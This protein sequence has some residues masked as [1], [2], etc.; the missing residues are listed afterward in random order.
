P[1]A[2]EWMQIT[3]EIALVLATS[4]VMLTFAG[5]EHVLQILVDLLFLFFLV[6]RDKP[7]AAAL[8]CC[9]LLVGATRYEG[10]FLV[11]VGCLLLLWRREIWVAFAAGIAGLGPALA[12]GAYSVAHGSHWLPNTL[13]VKATNPGQL[14]LRPA[15]FSP[16]EQ[17]LLCVYSLRQGLGELFLIACGL[18]AFGLFFRGLLSRRT[19]WML[20][21]YVGTAILHGQF[22]RLNWVYRYEGYLIALGLFVV[23][24]A[25]A[26]VW[27]RRAELSAKYMRPGAFAVSMLA[28]CLVFFIPRARTNIR[29]VAP[30]AAAIYDQQFQMARFLSTYYETTNIAANDIGAI[31]FYGDHSDLLDLAGLASLDVT[32]SLAHKDFNT[33]RIRELAEKHGTRIAI[34]YPS[35]FKDSLAFPADWVQVGTWT[36]PRENRY[37]VGGTTV[38]FYAVHAQDAPA[39][40]ANLRAFSPHLPAQVSE[41][42]MY[43]KV[44]NLLA[45]AR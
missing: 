36:I 18:F 28:V 1:D 17:A 13:M 26:D 27:T 45:S 24:N 35:W 10:L 4:L 16:Q 31:T 20:A 8:C 19:Q 9:A 15:V 6:E 41:A 14:R 33:Q 21:V 42:G 5:M 32:D 39:L 2:P 7:R 43:K 37:Y 3:L 38:A 12:M 44:S 11:F 25:A 29:E 30:R 22:S 23:F 34:A 40:A